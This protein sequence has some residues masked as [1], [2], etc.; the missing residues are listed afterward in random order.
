MVDRVVVTCAAV[1]SREVKSRQASLLSLR[2]GTFLLS[3]A[4]RWPLIKF[5]SRSSRRP[6]IMSG[7]DLVNARALVSA[8]GDQSRVYSE[9]S[10][11][12]N[13]SGQSLLAAAV[14]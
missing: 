2:L 13:G 12:M 10:N 11:S 7:A 5:V 9:D 4:L 14:S 3:K 6:V 1:L 8:A